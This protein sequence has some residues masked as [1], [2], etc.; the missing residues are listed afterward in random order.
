MNSAA[1]LETARHEF[2]DDDARDRAAIGAEKQ[3]F[4]GIGLEHG[5]PQAFA[6]GAASGGIAGGRRIG[7][8]GCVAVK[9]AG[10]LRVDLKG[11]ATVGADVIEAALRLAGID[12]LG[13]AAFGAAE[14]VFQRRHSSN[15]IW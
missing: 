13:A 9:L 6:G 7:L 5:N 14:D 10:L 1:T 3:G 11:A 4:V 2:L 8:N 15:S 12:N